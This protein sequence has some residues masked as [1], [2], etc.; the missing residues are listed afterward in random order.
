MQRVGVGLRAVAA[1][2]DMIILFAAVWVIAVLTG[3]TTDEGFRLEGGPFFLWVVLSLSY[4]IVLE[5]VN[6]ATP[7]KRLIGLKVTRSD[8]NAPLDWSASIVRNVLRI[9]DGLPLF[10]LAGAILI[11]TSEKKAAPGRSGGRH[12]RGQDKG[13]G[14]L[15]DACDDRSAVRPGSGSGAAVP[16]HP[17]RNPCW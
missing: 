1:I 17:V 6:G 9:I 13:T 8:G 12:H 16:R 2:I 10:Y 11:W 3:G 15:S 5:T 7:G 14:R 4:Y